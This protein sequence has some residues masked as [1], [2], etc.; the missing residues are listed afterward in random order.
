[1]LDIK[2]MKEYYTDLPSSQISTSHREDILALIK[3]VETLRPI[4]PSTLEIAGEINGYANSG[5]PFSANKVLEK[6][7]DKFISI[8]NRA[9]LTRKALLLLV[10]LDAY[11]NASGGAK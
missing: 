3:E 7:Y 9:L 1:M 10:D 8:E 2:K 4:E 11:F 6:H 5:N